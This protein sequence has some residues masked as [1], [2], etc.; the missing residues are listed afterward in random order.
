MLMNHGIYFGLPAIPEF[1]LRWKLTQNT[2]EP[3][4]ELRILGLDPSNKLFLGERLVLAVLNSKDT[5]LDISHLPH[6]Y[7]MKQVL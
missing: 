3:L 4:K 7:I 6:I 1:L 5:L 2:T